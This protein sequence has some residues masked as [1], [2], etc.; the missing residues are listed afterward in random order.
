LT[1]KVSSEILSKQNT[2]VKI[3][4]RP[5]GNQR[6]DRKNRVGYEK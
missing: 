6:P 5:G 1:L 2:E 4:F 3:N